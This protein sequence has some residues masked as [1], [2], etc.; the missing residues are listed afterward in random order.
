MWCKI[1]DLL[2]TARDWSACCS[3]IAMFQNPCFSDDPV[4][5]WGISLR[6]AVALGADLLGTL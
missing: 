6:T 4:W 3:A 1:S 5:M 2:S